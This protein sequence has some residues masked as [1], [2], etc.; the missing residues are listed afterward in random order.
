MR[1]LNALAVFA[2]VAETRSFSAGGL[3]LGISASGASRAVSR[4]ESDL[5]VRLL[6]RTTR[7]V[8]L[9]EEGAA[10]LERCRRILDEIAEAEN[11]ITSDRARP[12]GRLR[13]HVPVGFGKK[14]VVPALS[15]FRERYPEITLDV[16]LNDR[17]PDLAQEGIDVGVRVGQLGD[18]HVV[19]R[20]LCRTRFIT[21]AAPS[22]LKRR[23]TPKMPEDLARH[24]CLAYAIP[25]TGRYRP[26]EFAKGG[27]NF[28]IAVS[29]TLNINN[30]EALVDAAIAG[31]GIATVASFIAADDI[32]EGRLKLILADYM[33]E[34]PTIYVTYLNPKQASARVRAMVDFLAETLPADPPWERGLTPPRKSKR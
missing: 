18:T 21:V 8:K 2:S 28:S 19:A 10:Y 14:I 20:R 4:L 15:A 7:S 22:Y 11:A 1:N 23:G 9:T 24:D 3:R 16:E 33:A 29:G 6:A 31:A 34:G 12:H 5:G 27:R 17:A 30:G 25:G 13:L 32:R 26:W